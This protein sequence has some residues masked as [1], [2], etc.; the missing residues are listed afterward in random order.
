[1]VNSYKYVGI[2]FT[3]K[4]S[5]SYACEDLVSRGKKAVVDIMNKMYKLEKTHSMYIFFKI[6]DAQ[7]QSIVLY[8]AE[9]W[10]TRQASRLTYIY[11]P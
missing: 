8:G 4:I 11:L 1:M 5:F 6:V 7:V 3:T 9:L 2:F 10:G